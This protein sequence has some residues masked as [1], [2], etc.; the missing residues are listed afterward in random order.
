MDKPAYKELASKYDEEVKEYD[1][2]GHDV[3]FGM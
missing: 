1:S 3:I 2:Y